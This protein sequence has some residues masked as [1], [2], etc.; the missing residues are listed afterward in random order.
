MRFR[1]EILAASAM[2]LSCGA[3]MEPLRPGMS[4]C[5]IRVRAIPK[6][7]Y[8]APF[9]APGASDVYSERGNSGDDADSGEFTRVDY[10]DVED[11]VVWL[12]PRVQASSQPAIPPTW[13]ELDVR[14]KQPPPLIVAAQH[15]A[16]RFRNA[17]STS[18]AAYS[19]S[20]GNDF[21]L[22]EIAPNAAAEYVARAPGLIE[23]LSPAVNAP[24]ARVFVVSSPWSKRARSGRNVYFG[25]LPP[26]SYTARCW[27]ER[28]PG[29]ESAATLEPDRVC[30]T[31][32]TLSVNSLPKAP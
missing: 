17:G 20:D 8:V 11:V 32:L 5:R 9:Q 25:N 3:C 14:R 13:V 16:I 18:C 2:A 27:H 23:V 7:G 24:L 28:L 29:S 26:G 19:V 15:G 12:E 6:E 1:R 10:D 21:D 4:G 31:S 30:E 22:G